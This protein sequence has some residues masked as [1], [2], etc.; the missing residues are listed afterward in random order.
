MAIF[1]KSYFSLTSPPLPFLP[2]TSPLLSPPLHLPSSPRPPTGGGYRAVAAHPGGSSLP[3][4][5]PRFGRRGEEVRPVAGGAGR[6]AAAPLLPSLPDLD[7][8]GRGRIVAGG[9]GPT[10]AGRVRA[11][12]AKGGRGGGYVR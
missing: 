11:A 10:T 2:S 4:L 5:P 8:G 1:S 6:M 3:S 9:P 7:R 12:D